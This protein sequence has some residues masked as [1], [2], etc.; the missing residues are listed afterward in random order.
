MGTKAA[1]RM[2][3][4]STVGVNF[5]KMFMNSFYTQRSPK[6]KMPDYLTVIFVLLGSAHK[7]AAHK[8]LVKL[9]LGV[10]FHQCFGRIF[11]RK[12]L[13]SSYILVTKSTFI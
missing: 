9:T 7:K 3:I 1:Q 10:N 11:H 2:M 13:F 4:N 12:V 6:C 8:M 5:N